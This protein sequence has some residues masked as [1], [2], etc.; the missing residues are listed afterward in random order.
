MYAETKERVDSVYTKNLKKKID[1][2]SSIL[3]YG[4]NKIR[5]VAAL[6]AIFYKSAI[7]PPVDSVSIFLKLIFNR[8]INC[9]EFFQFKC[10]DIIR[11]FMKPSAE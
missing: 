5:E 1:T 10:F 7:K 3:K 9:L 8:L 4:A 11:G 2:T 6:T